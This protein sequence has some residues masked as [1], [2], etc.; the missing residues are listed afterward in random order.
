MCAKLKKLLAIPLALVFAGALSAH[1][2]TSVAVS[3]LGAF[4]SS[5]STVGAQ[6]NPSNQPGF[7]LE[8]RHISNP[9]VGYDFS[10]SF[11]GANQAYQCANSTCPLIAPNGQ[12][13]QARAQALT[14]NWVVSFPIANL[15]PF[16]LAGGGFERFS[17][18]GTQTA[19]T[20]SQTKGVFDYGAG[21][22]WTV[23]PHLGL[24]FQ[25]RGYVYKAPQLATAFS[26]T[27]KFTHDAE[28]MIGAYF[29]F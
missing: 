13:V 16:A 22:D 28:P 1:A 26:S 2:Q 6:Q 14:L 23:L 3:A 5:T 24:R 25:Y 27:D 12:F 10:Y 7:M 15:R 11:R 20:G 9:L 17:P 8:L 18:S 19:P 29:N 4:P 21:L